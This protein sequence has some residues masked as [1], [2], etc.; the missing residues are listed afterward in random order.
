MPAEV[1]EMTLP[2]PTPV[3]PIVIC[4]PPLTRMPTP[5][6]SATVPSLLVPILFPLMWTFVAPEISIVDESTGGSEELMSIGGRIKQVRNGDYVVAD[7]DVIRP[8]ERDVDSDGLEGLMH[9]V[10]LP[11]DRRN[12]LEW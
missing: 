2:S 5:A 10:L 1:P 12:S 8:V 7:G 4:D 6:P 3:P 9:Q 11:G